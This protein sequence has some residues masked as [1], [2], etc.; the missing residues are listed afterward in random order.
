MG[1][2]QD[3]CCSTACGAPLAPRPSIHH[4]ETTVSQLAGCVHLPFTKVMRSQETIH[5]GSHLVAISINLGSH[6]RGHRLLTSS[7]RQ[8]LLNTM[9]RSFCSAASGEHVD[10]R[11]ASMPRQH[12]LSVQTSTH[13][14]D[15]VS[16]NDIVYSANT[17]E[18]TGRQAWSIGWDQVPLDSP[19]PKQPFL[20]IQLDAT[21]KTNRV[22]GVLLVM[23][24]GRAE[25]LPPPKNKQTGEVRRGSN[26]N[27]SS[28]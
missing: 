2:K 3:S 15:L 8:L 14:Q 25:S 19:T 10:R 1:G 13:Y 23:T 24:S 21:T 6:T 12:S 28:A 11:R 4:A 16:N 20:A 9:P 27:N 18:L 7:S 17:L 22:E 5:T 26:E